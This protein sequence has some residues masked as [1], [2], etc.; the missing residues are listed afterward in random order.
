MVRI[1]SIPDVHGSHQWEAVKSVPK[2]SYD[3]IVFHG[4]YFDSWENQW[5][6]QGENFKT[7]CDF[8]REDTE[9]RK[10]LIGNHDFAYL[11]F[12]HEIYSV[13]DTTAEYDF[14]TIQ[15]FFKCYKKTLKVINDIKSQIIYHKDED[16]FIQT[17]LKEHFSEEIAERLFKTAFGKDK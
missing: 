4:D 13:F 1:L 5:P 8:V 11:S 10:L 14:I 15:E 17:S 7:I 16:E 3:Y 9:H 12:L 6:D 2:D